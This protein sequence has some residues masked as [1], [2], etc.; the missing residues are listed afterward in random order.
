VR[1]EVP[2]HVETERVVDRMVESKVD[3]SVY[4]GRIRELQSEVAHL[5]SRPIPAPIDTTSY[6][7]RIRELESEISLL[8]SRR[9]EVVERIVEK[10]VEVPVVHE[11]IVEVAS[12]PVAR[13]LTGCGPFVGFGLLENSARQNTGSLPVE[14]IY[15]HGPAWEAGMRIDDEISEIGQSHQPIN[16]LNQVR[17]VI[18]REAK[19]GQPLRV[20]GTRPNGERYE[21][22]ILVKTATEKARTYSDLFYDTRAHQKL[23]Q[24]TKA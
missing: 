12:K 14:T 9:P 17:E 7:R 15:E 22:S 20:L 5:R 10:R 3:V 4:E 1:V 24:T 19:V 21:T 8:R 23:G 6:E 2:V 11:R 13:D 16:S 18:M